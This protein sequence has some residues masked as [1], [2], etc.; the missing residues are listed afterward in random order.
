MF[1]RLFGCRFE[2]GH[3]IFV[4]PLVPIL[5]HFFKLK[6]NLQAKLKYLVQFDIHIAHSQ[7][8]GDYIGPKFY[9]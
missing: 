9:N 7:K 4:K 6:K 5:S 1:E 3:L 8:V 2:C